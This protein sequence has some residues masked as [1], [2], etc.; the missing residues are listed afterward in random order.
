MPRH[1]PPKAP[2]R[3]AILPYA[4]S[5]SQTKAHRIGWD[6]ADATRPLTPPHTHTHTNT[7]RRDANPYGIYDPSW[8]LQ[9][10]CPEPDNMCHSG[11]PWQVGGGSRPLGRRPPAAGLLAAGVGLLA[12]GSPLAL[13]ATRQPPPHLQEITSAVRHSLSSRPLPADLSAPPL[14]R[15]ARRGFPRPAARPAIAPAANPSR[16]PS[17]PPGSREQGPSL[18]RV[19]VPLTQSTYVWCAGC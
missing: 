4:P 6:G 15:S 17:A 19:F 10:L 14:C 12:A 8:N 2:H 9:V 13:A 7:H 16:T 3:A 18:H 5:Q 11:G 1:V